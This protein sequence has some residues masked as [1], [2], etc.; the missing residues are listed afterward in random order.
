VDSIEFRPL[1]LTSPRFLIGASDFFLSHSALAAI[2]P[3]LIL[4]TIASLAS[5]ISWVIK[6][7]TLPQDQKHSR[8]QEQQRSDIGF[9]RAK[10]AAKEAPEMR[11]TLIRRCTNCSCSFGC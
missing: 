11:A 1:H 4:E 2:N 10:A 9:A 3:E 6:D 8:K 5:G 7:E